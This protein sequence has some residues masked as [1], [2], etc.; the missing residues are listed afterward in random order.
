MVDGI[1]T[2]SVRHDQGVLLIWRHEQHIH[3]RRRS[4]ITDVRQSDHGLDEH[5]THTTDIDH[6]RIRR[7]HRVVIDDN[8]VGVDERPGPSAQGVG[9]N[10]G[11]EVAGAVLQFEGRGDCLAVG[12]AGGE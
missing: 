4:P 10:G 9:E 2:A 3:V 1:L 7:S 5:T 11:A 12:A 8:G 6:G